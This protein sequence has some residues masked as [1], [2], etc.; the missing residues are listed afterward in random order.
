MSDDY[1][2]GDRDKGESEINMAAVAN[3]AMNGTGAGSMV[4]GGH[5]GRVNGINGWR[6]PQR[7]SQ[8]DQWLAEAT[9]AES[10]G[11]G[12]LDRACGGAWVVQP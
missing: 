1:E 11:S 8:W 4:G 6:R 10:M 3:A 5:S 9:A 7:P 12:A 2:G